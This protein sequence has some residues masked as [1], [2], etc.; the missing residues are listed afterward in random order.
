MHSCYNDAILKQSVSIT[1][2]MKVRKMQADYTSHLRM[3]KLYDDYN[4]EPVIHNMNNADNAIINAINE[5]YEYDLKPTKHAV[6]IRPILLLIK[7]LSKANEVNRI[8]SELPI[9][10][11][12]VLNME[13]LEITEYAKKILSSHSNNSYGMV[14]EAF[15]SALESLYDDSK[16]SITERIGLIEAYVLIYDFISALD[17]SNE[18]RSIIRM[19]SINAS[20]YM[21]CIQKMSG[22]IDTDEAYPSEFIYETLKYESTSLK[23]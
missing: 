3:L 19:L 12:N 15:N 11:H 21:E 1:T 22:I 17:D 16:M 10:I 9:V 8:T 23:S 5:L 4:T 20:E 18:I 7:Q 2:V 14:I 6:R 13:S